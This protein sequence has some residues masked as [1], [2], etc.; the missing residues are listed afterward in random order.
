MFNHLDKKGVYEVFQS[1]YRQLHS[2]E[3]ALFCVQNDILKAVDSCGGA[4]LVLLDLSAAFGTIDLENLI[5]TVDTYCGIKGDPLKCFFF[6]FFIIFERSSSICTNMIY[7]LSTAK[8]VVWCPSRL[9]PG[10]STFQIYT[11]PLG[12]I[13]LRHGLIYHLYADDTHLYM[14]FKP[15]DMTSK[16]DALSRIEAC[17]AEI[18]IWTNANFLKL[19]DDKTELLII[20]TPPRAQQKFRFIDRVVNNRSLQVMIHQET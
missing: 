7:F 12:R 17:M 10:A 19:N 5:R 4:I 13:I 16:C 6:L 8:Y 9:S 20:T 15:S 3:T 11:P 14:A 2:T 18:Q 1:A